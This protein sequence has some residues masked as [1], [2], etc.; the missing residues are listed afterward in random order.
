MEGGCL[1]GSG[2]SSNAADRPGR[3]APS[4]RGV[5][6]AV[7]LSVRFFACCGR[8]PALKIEPRCFVSSAL[9]R[10]YAIVCADA[11]QE[12]DLD[13]LEVARA[14]CAWGPAVLQLRAKGRPDSQALEWLTELR[15]TTRRSNTLLY[16]ND[17]PDLAQWA[18][19]D[20]VHVGQQD[21]PIAEV[22]ARFP[23]LRVGVS[24]HG[25][26]QMRRALEEAPDYVALGPIFS[27]SS[28]KNPE[29]TLGISGLRLVGHEARRRGI[30]LVAIGG[31]GAR[32]MR[33]VL[34]WATRAAL[35]SAL[36]PARSL[37][38]V[39]LEEAITE[40]LAALFPA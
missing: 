11:C 1:G 5:D 29:A 4:A 28:K 25:A 17:R 39:E 7:R 33:G 12:R 26:E 37:R 16:M 15:E 19:C 38:G 30:E 36:L 13:L 27:T 2:A 34:K 8:A 21:W 9:H 40:R 14:V 6:R 23:D 22:R 10:L 18:G 31:I 3:V 35:I 20:G 24:T 32:S